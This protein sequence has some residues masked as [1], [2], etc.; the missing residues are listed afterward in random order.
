[1]PTYPMLLVAAFL[2]GLG[3]CVYHPADYAILADA[4]S[5][6]RMGRA[7][8]IHTFAGLLGGAL[9]P[10]V[11][12]GLMAY[13]SFGAALAVHRAAGPGRRGRRCC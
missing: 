8:S 13:A 6:H 1:M 10:V 7:F 2:A 4:M 9:T 12:F 5:E 11:L 3:N